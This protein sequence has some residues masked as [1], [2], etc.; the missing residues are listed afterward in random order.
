MWQ[1]LGQETIRPKTHLI[2]FKPAKPP[3]DLGPGL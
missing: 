3:S 2:C 1:A